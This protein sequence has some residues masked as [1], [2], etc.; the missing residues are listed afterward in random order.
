MLPI[1]T[2]GNIVKCDFFNTWRAPNVNQ[3]T[4]ITPANKEIKLEML[5]FQS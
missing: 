2:I 4:M 5:T 3:L 1:T